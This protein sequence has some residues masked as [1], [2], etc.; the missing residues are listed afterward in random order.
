MTRKQA[1][2]RI[3]H[4]LDYTYATRH[5]DELTEAVALFDLD[6]ADRADLPAHSIPFETAPSAV[7]DTAGEEA[8][9][10]CVVMGGVILPALD[11][12]AKIGGLLKTDPI[13]VRHATIR[14]E[15]P[16]PRLARVDNRFFDTGE[17]V[18]DAIGRVI[19]DVV[20]GFD[21]G[22]IAEHLKQRVLDAFRDCAE[23]GRIAATGEP[24]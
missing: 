5:D 9:P 8:R 13:M 22:A 3:R 21:P 14:L 2:E 23:A 11:T 24:A 12:G 18:E 20:V 15:K 16:L 6:T 7:V 10:Y 4:H 17:V 1:W 19:G